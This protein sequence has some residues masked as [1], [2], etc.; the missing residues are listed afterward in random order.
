[1]IGSWH[2]MAPERL[3]GREAD[4]RADMGRRMDL[5]TASLEINQRLTDALKVSLYLGVGVENIPGRARQ[6]RL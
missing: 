6:Q 2:Y 5:L 3:R 4:A 1:M